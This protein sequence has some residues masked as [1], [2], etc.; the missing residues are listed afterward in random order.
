VFTP[1]ENLLEAEMK[2]ISSALAQ[3]RPRLLVVLHSVLDS[4]LLAPAE[5]FLV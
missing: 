4:I 2:V 5:S 1:A 3:A